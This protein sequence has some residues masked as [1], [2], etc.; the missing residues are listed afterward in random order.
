MG[1]FGKVQRDVCMKI[2][3]S[4]FTCE[5]KNFVK[6]KCYKHIIVMQHFFFNRLVYICESTL[7]LECSPNLSK[8]TCPDMF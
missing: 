5:W 8:Q 6:P 4:H 2:E 1:S 7:L 3:T